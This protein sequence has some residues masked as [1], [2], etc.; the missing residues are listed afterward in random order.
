MVVRRDV[1]AAAGGEAEIARPHHAQVPVRPDHADARIA[2]GGEQGRRRVGRAIVDHDKLEVG[3][4][5]RQHAVDRVADE[6]GAVVG[7]HQHADGGRRGPGAR[8]GVKLRGGRCPAGARSC[9][10]L[11]SVSQG[12]GVLRVIHQPREKSAAPYSQ[13]EPS[14]S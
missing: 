11:R 6:R 14:L 12:G 3:N 13:I 4:R 9:E 7:G 2:A 10:F 1:D 8:R 5:L